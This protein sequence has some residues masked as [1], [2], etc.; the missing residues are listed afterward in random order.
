MDE[1]TIYYMIGFLVLLFLIII[2]Y[3]NYLYKNAEKEITILK[4][5]TKFMEDYQNKLDINALTKN[6]ELLN[7]YGTGHGMTLMWEMYI[8]NNPPNK[9]YNSSFNKLKP[10][11]KFGDSP[12]IYYQPKQGYLSIILKYTDNPFY[13]NYP[14]IKIENV[15]LQK[16][17]KYIMVI[18]D[19]N[20]NVFVNNKLVSS[21]T[22][23]NIP[24]IYLFEGIE[25]G[26][27]NNNFLG[28]IKNMKVLTRALTI[29]EIKNL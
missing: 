24:Y 25:L 4:G 5:P 3:Y 20:I 22:L 29:K 6:K 23:M 27:I 28:V 7:N 19:R 21:R 1:N 17:E 2:V 26:E 8:P 10:I 12:Q 15:K 18:Q 16:W 11:V 9:F 13:S 14:E